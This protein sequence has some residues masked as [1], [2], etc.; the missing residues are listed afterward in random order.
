MKEFIMDIRERKKSLN[1]K[2]AAQGKRRSRRAY[3]PGKSK[4]QQ[5]GE[6]V[7]VKKTPPSWN[8]L[9]PGILSLFRRFLAA[10]SRGSSQ[11]ELNKEFA[12]EVKSEYSRKTKKKK[13]CQAA[14]RRAAAAAAAAAAALPPPAPA[15]ATAAT[16]PVQPPPVP[17]VVQ[18]RVVLAH[19]GT[20]VSSGN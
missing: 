9:Q 6:R 19:S 11:E 14:A 17:P 13:E 10:M 12:L 18:R 5:R 2:D 1:A 3:T 7:Y 15:P 16:P 4:E 8:A 20:E